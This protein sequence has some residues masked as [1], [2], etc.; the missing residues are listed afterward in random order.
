MQRLHLSHTPIQEGKQ[1]I[2]HLPPSK[3]IAA[4]RLILSALRGLSIESLGNEE[5]NLPDDLYALQQ[6]L[7]AQERGESIVDVGESGTAMRFMLAYLAARTRQA[8]QLVGKGRQ[9]ERP[10]APLVAAL[11]ALGAEIAYLQHEG[12]PPLLIKPS[13]LK[14]QRIVLDASQSS[15]YL[16]AL[17]LIAPLVEGNGYSIDTSY[18]G[19]ASLPYALITIKEM[20]DA[21]FIWQQNGLHFSYLST[22]VA[23]SC[24]HI[25]TESDWSAASYAYLLMSLLRKD[26]SGYTTE[27]KLPKLLANSVQGDREIL[28]TIYERL[29]VRT[30]IEGSGISLSLMPA[31]DND[32]IALDCRN[33]PDLVPA[34]VASMVANS[35]SFVFTGVAHLRIKES[36]RLEA[37]QTELH[38]VGIRLSLGEDSIAWDG[39]YFPIAN[40]TTPVLLN[41]HHDHRIAM[42]LAPLMAHLCPFG[43]VI[44][45]ADCVTKSYPLYWQEIEKLGYTTKTL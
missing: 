36:N 33:T 17:L 29:G 30:T 26:L 19:L 10:I 40:A 5:A 42:A 11:R 35:R 7:L 18:Y 41:P 3:S 12:Y 16:S 43:L 4:R 8:I 31:K 13:K 2:L 23:R 25:S 22:S 20:R 28:T 32:S 14:A 38:K 39:K 24:C 15:Q 27:I 45:D 37:L 44:E 34:L 6:A 21:G 9:Y 1:V